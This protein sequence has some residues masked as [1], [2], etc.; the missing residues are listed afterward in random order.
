MNEKFEEIKCKTEEL[1]TW[2]K[3]KYVDESRG[4]K[5]ATEI[6]DMNITAVN[7]YN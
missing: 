4:K 5:Y 6:I 3:N 7:K 2:K 1:Q